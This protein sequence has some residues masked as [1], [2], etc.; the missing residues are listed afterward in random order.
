MDREAGK[1]YG[2][3]GDRWVDGKIDVRCILWEMMIDE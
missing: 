2:E 1:D 3:E